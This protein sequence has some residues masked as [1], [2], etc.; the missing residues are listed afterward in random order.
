VTTAR[1]DGPRRAR[2]TPTTIRTTTTPSAVSDIAR[3]ARKT[4][5]TRGSACR[6]SFGAHRRTDPSD[7]ERRRFVQGGR[8]H[9]RFSFFGRAERGVLAARGRPRKTSSGTPRRVSFSCIFSRVDSRRI[10][11]DDVHDDVARRTR[12]TNALSQRACR[13]WCDTTTRWPR[14]RSRL[15]SRSG[16]CTRAKRA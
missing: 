15:G 14:R 9:H 6:A 1:V 2:A 16:S 13:R 5:H 4:T 10:I 7:D 3:G 11:V 12:R 8:T